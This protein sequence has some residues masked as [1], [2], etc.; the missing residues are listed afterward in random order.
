MSDHRKQPA[1][2]NLETIEVRSEQAITRWWT[3][4]EFANH[5][6]LSPRTIYEAISQGKLVCHRFGDRRGIRISELERLRWEKLHETNSPPILQHQ[7]AN[8]QSKQYPSLLVEK[9]FQI[10][11]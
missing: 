8:A 3:V 6:R 1:G 5:Y 2:I 7:V 10:G 9:H 4:A 11:R